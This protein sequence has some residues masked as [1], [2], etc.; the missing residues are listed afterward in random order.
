MLKLTKELIAAIKSNIE[1]LEI[2]DEHRGF[3][4]QPVIK[5][6]FIT[7]ELEDLEKHLKN[8]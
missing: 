4:E 8:T 7:D 1:Y 5:L 6:Q 2:K 3:L